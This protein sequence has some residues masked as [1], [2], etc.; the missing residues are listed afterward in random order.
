MSKPLS[1]GSITIQNGNYPSDLGHL[2]PSYIHF[3]AGN[4][5]GNSKGEG[6][7]Y[8]SRLEKEIWKSFICQNIL[9]LLSQY[10]GMNLWRDCYCSRSKYF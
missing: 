3:Y 2:L 10:F 4:R 6:M 8:C 1:G 5:G 9:I 7:C